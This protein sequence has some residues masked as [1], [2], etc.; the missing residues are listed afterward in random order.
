MQREPPPFVWAVPDEKNIL[1][2]EFIDVSLS[3]LAL[4]SRIGN[5]IIVCRPSSPLACWN[6]P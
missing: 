3:T 6:Q 5:Y 2:C 4:T 1:I